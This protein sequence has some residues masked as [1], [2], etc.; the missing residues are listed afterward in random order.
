MP[1]HVFGGLHRLRW[2]VV[3]T[4]LAL[5]TSFPQLGLQS[6][7]TRQEAKAAVA[8]QARPGAGPVDRPALA[9]ATPDRAVA[10]D[11][12]PPVVP[13]GVFAGAAPRTL[14]TQE[15][16]LVSRQRD[17]L[18]S[19]DAPVLARLL[20]RPGCVL[21]DT[22]LLAYFAVDE[23]QPW[24]SWQVSLYDAATQTEQASTTLTRDDLERSTCAAQREYCRSLAARDGWE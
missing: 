4:A 10:L 21:G 17:R 2:L 12:R 18:R 24:T 16:Q 6:G 11:Q 8:L 14:S 5:I 3:V 1:G 9:L 13:Q 20:L 19:A 22:S 23:D 7:Q 15:W